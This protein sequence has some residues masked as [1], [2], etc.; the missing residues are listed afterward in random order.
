MRVYDPRMRKEKVVPFLCWA[1]LAFLVVMA[2]WIFLT[3]L[4]TGRMA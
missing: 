2:G 1:Y 4:I 3:W